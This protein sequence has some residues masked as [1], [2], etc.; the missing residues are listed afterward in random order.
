MN[1]KDIRIVV[2]YTVALSELEVPENVYEQLVEAYYGNDTIEIDGSPY[3]ADALD[4]LTTNIR[5]RDSCDWS[6]EI[7]ELSTNE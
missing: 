1:I 5:E 4:W 7:D 2:T 6:V 3:F